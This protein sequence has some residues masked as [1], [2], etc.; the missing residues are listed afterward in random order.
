MVL[1]LK[2]TICLRVLPGEVSSPWKA[3][4]AIKTQKS[5]CD[6][7]AKDG[8]LMCMGRYVG[9]WQSLENFLWVQSTRLVCLSSSA[10]QKG[11]PFLRSFSV[12]NNKWGL[13]SSL[14]QARKNYLGR[15]FR[16]GFLFVCFSI[17]TGWWCLSE[18]HEMEN[19][20]GVFIRPCAVHTFRPRQLEIVVWVLVK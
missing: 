11:V 16:K 10:K 6:N 7:R 17:F 3:W 12:L 18:A 13:P 15:L 8:L 19:K 1:L 9:L 14:H 2:I 4:H 20:N 5:Y